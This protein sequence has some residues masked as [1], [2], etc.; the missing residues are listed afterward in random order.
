MTNPVCKSLQK[1]LMLF[2]LLT[3][4]LGL[5]AQPVIT[6][7][8][9]G[10]PT[11]TGGDLAELTRASGQVMAED[12]L[13]Q[14]FE[15][16][17]IANGRASQYLG[18]S[19]L[20]D[21]IFQRQINP[22]DL[23]VQQQM[24][25]YFTKNARITYENFVLG[26]ND[27]VAQV[28]ANPALLPYELAVIGFHPPEIPVPD[29]TVP[30]VIR[31][32]RFILQQFSPTQVPT[33]QLDNLVALE[34]LAAR[35]GDTAGL[36][37]F[38]DIDPQTN[39]VKANDTI[40]PNDDCGGF[41]ICPSKSAKKK[42]EK[43]E[44]HQSFSADPTFKAHAKA[45][46]E[47]SKRLK[48]IKKLNKKYVPALGSNGQA[49][50][51]CRSKTGNTLLRGAPQPNFN[52][53][54][55]LYEIRAVN[56]M[57]SGD[58]FCFSGMPFGGISIYNNFGLTVQVGHLPTNDFLVEPL[59]NVLSSRTE[60]IYI[61]GQKLPYVLTVYRSSSGG[62]VIDYPF[63]EIPGTML[64]LR[65]RLFNKQLKG[66]NL[67]AELPFMTSVHDLF[68]KGL[69]RKY[70]SDLLG[71]EG[72]CADGFGNIG[73]FQA[74]E[75]TKLPPGYNRRLPQGVPNFPAATNDVYFSHKTLKK[76]LHDMNTK[77]GYYTGWNTLF[78]Q[79]AQG[80]EDTVLAGFPLSR[81]YWL[82]DFLYT[83][84]TI[85]F[86]DLMTLTFRQAV[87]NS[88]VAFND[89]L[90]QD[91]DW[92]TPLF[93]DLFFKAVR[94]SNP[95]PDQLKALNLLETFE[96]NWFNGNEQQVIATRNVSNQFILA[97]AWLL[98]FSAN[99]LN[100]FLGGT[101]FEVNPG[102]PGN[103]LPDTNAFGN[104]NDQRLQA[105]LLGRILKQQCDNTVYFP[106]WLAGIP[107]LNAVIVASLDQALTN[108]G[109][110][111]ATWGNNKRPIYAFE[112]AILGPVA[113]TLAFNGS[114]VYLLVE[115]GPNGPVRKEATLPLGESGQVLGFPG[116][117]IFNPHNFDQLPYF[118]T[119]TLRTLNY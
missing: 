92:F 24:D 15:Y 79:E 72:Q 91:A 77:Q 9:F 90:N 18:P 84:N 74:T 3:F 86:N 53:P 115:F 42:K 31:M 67:I 2:C 85:S 73:A 59:T 13:W 117:P 116:A 11:I 110:F 12:R 76:P 20:D 22:T 101:Y 95:T 83:L 26:L 48:A 43:K 113:E 99:V 17:I 50:S 16:T 5:I 49:I 40:V 70:V 25:I 75:W 63:S 118:Q 106:D 39:Q 52:H 93:K 100:T 87:A 69:K 23:E 108:L 61:A 35:F 38:N 109:G 55:D 44:L 33:Y 60:L 57:F 29:F 102:A 10:V 28:N 98:N 8:N 78:K 4:P 97:S 80:S 54:S 51:P 46:A 37:I 56:D 103:P 27:Y 19:F 62:W 96:G 47:V 34:T 71:L 104:D 6:R 68:H 14:V 119:F 36:A 112:N 30:D 82:N 32:N 45:A 1:T 111:P 94:S 66:L 107:D 21:D 88:V 114:G 81:G 105:N 65:S 89:S 64:T 7:D 58:Y 41:T